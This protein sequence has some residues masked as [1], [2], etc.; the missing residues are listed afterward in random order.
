MAVKKLGGTKWYRKA[1]HQ[2]GTRWEAV[3]E[4]IAE[5]SLRTFVQFRLPPYGYCTINEVHDAA[6]SMTVI[7]LAL[8]TLADGG[9]AARVPEIRHSRNRT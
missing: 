1:T 6:F 8:G 4:P 9:L 5:P 2:I 3:R 7:S